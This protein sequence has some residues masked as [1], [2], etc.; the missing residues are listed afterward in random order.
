M[1]VDSE[2][3]LHQFNVPTLSL[4]HLQRKQLIGL[5]LMKLSR[6]LTDI[7]DINCKDYFGSLMTFVFTLITVISKSD[8]VPKESRQKLANYLFQRFGSGNFTPVILSFKD[9]DFSIQLIMSGA[10]QVI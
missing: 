10:I 3:L 1:D 6:L 2:D 4:R 7:L 9:Y 8:S 5:R